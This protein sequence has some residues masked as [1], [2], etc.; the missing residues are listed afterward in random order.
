M[1]M[2]SGDMPLKKTLFNLPRDW[3]MTKYNARACGLAP[4]A[5]SPRKDVFPQYPNNL[6][7]NACIEEIIC[8]FRLSRHNEKTC[9]SYGYAWRIFSDYFYDCFYQRITSQVSIS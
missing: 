2:G 4:H 8:F 6:H 1:E 9:N 7:E 3:V 5:V